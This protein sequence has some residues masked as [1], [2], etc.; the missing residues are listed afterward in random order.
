MVGREEWRERV[1][2]SRKKERTSFERQ[3]EE[4]NGESAGKLWKEKSEEKLS[5]V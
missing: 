2:D 4:K 5:P 3:Q 1:Q